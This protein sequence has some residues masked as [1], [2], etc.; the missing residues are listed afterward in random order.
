MAQSPASRQHPCLGNLASSIHA[1]S[2]SGCTSEKGRLTAL[3]GSS[4]DSPWACAPSLPSSRRKMTLFPPLELLAQKKGVCRFAPKNLKER[5]T[6]ELHPDTQLPLQSD[7]EV[8][9]AASLLQADR[10]MVE[11]NARAVAQIGLAQP[12][13]DTCHSEVTSH[14]LCLKD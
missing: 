9:A 4:R 10:A 5:Y 7:D 2:C 13:G 12:R 6:V 14:M 11:T 1:S 3:G 8:A